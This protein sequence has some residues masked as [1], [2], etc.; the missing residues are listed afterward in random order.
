MSVFTPLLVCGA[1]ISTWVVDGTLQNEGSPTLKERFIAEAPK[2]W[3]AWEDQFARG[4]EASVSL[5]LRSL[6]D[7]PKKKSSQQKN[8]KFKSARGKYILYLSFEG[9]DET[10]VFGRNEHYWFNL[11]KDLESEPLRIDAASTFFSNLDNTPE[12]YLHQFL[13]LPY[14]I[15]PVLRYASLV[16][17][18]L[19]FHITDIKQSVDD[20]EELVRVD[21]VR[22]PLIPRSTDLDQVQSGRLYFSPVHDWALRR[23]EIYIDDTPTNKTEPSKSLGQE[24]NENTVGVEKIV[25]L[26]DYRRENGTRW[27][28][29]RVAIEFFVKGERNARPQAIVCDFTSWRSYSI[30]PSEF[31]LSAFGFPESVAYAATNS[32]SDALWPALCGVACLVGASVIWRYKRRKYGVR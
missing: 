12:K 7:D 29:S 30:P 4:V 15:D 26:V 20:K 2:A 1:V 31:T 32:R 21:F 9:G 28:I 8:L 23:S 14:A 25:T 19:F 11:K 6:T 10:F 3:L 24:S 22:S 13:R 27:A 5:G 17:D 18:K 16:E